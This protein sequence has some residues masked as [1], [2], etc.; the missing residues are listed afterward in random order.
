MRSCKFFMQIIS[1]HDIQ[2]KSYFNS[3][4]LSYMKLNICVCMC[5][6][7]WMHEYMETEFVCVYWNIISIFITGTL[8]YFAIVTMVI[9]WIFCKHHVLVLWENAIIIDPE[10]IVSDL[11]I[12]HKV[13]RNHCR[14][15][16]DLGMCLCSKVKWSIHEAKSHPLWLEFTH[17][18]V[19]VSFQVGTVIHAVFGTLWILILGF[20]K[21]TK[22]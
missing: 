10:N 11:Q 6:L 5:I 20:L 13:I 3:N 9:F 16:N 7:K 12:H 14:S 22:V 17:I 15:Y 19:C 8:W 18:R 21:Y 2:N 1:K 4:L